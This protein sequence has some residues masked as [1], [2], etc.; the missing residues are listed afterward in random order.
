MPQNI[1]SARQKIEQ[2][3]G[4]ITKLSTEYSSPAWGFDSSD[5]LNQALI[6][7]TTL[8]PI[9]LL[10]TIWEIEKEFGRERGTQNEELAKFQS[11]Q[12]GII[13]YSARSM[14]IDIMFYGDEQISTPLLTIPHPLIAEREFAL[15]SLADVCPE[16]MLPNQS[17]TI[18][19]LLDDIC[20]K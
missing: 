12:D 4:K 17:K 10:E 16:N 11:R 13:G 8:T 6:C 2:R 9:E 5:F 7:S 15:R 19:E 3:I 1:L 20:K 14:D 18:S